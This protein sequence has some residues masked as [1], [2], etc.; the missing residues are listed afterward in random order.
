V[1]F[2]AKLSCRDPRIEHLL[3]A[4]K[5]ELEADEP[6]GRLYADSVGIALASQLVR[7][8]A[9]TV[10]DLP[11]GGLQKRRLR[12]VLAYIDDRL[13]QDLTLTELAGV[14]GVSLSHLKLLFKRSVGVSVHRYVVQRR[15]QRATE[16]LTH[17]KEP[18]A[19]VA[20]QAG[21]ANQSHMAR[22]VRQ[23]LGVTPKTL[24]DAL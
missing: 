24:R 5:C 15:V 16:L 11:S 14:A 2:I 17:T 9:R 10:P 3:W 23:S 12:R 20:L 21:F 7:R 13:S 1:A 8:Y 6:Q 22:W 18:L 4:L 19:E